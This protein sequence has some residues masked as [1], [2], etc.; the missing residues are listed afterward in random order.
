MRVT[1]IAHEENKIWN[2]TEQQ[3]ML[4]WERGSDIKYT[5]ISW[6]IPILNC[7]GRA[8]KTVVHKHIQYILLFMACIPMPP[9]LF[10]IKIVV[11]VP[12]QYDT[13]ILSRIVKIQVEYQLSR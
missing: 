4:R 5:L 3:E 9:P 1:I 11:Y 7:N 12:G 6:S 8:Y 10:K 13:M 2:F